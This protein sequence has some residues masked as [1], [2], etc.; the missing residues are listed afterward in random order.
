MHVWGHRRLA[1]AAMAVVMGMVLALALGGI[2]EPA[3]GR[4]GAPRRTDPC[5]GTSVVDHQHSLQ[6]G[7]TPDL[8]ANL[9]PVKG[10]CY[11]DVSKGEAQMTVDALQSVNDEHNEFFFS[12][13]SLHSVRSRIPPDNTARGSTGRELGF[14]KLISFGPEFA[15]LAGEDEQIAEASVGGDMIDRFTVHGTKAFLFVDRSS[16]DSRY[17]FT[18]VRHGVQGDL[19]GATRA[20][21][22]KWVRKYLAATVLVGTESS[23]LVDALVR[24]DGYAY[25]DYP[26]DEITETWVKGPL[27]AVP[28]SQHQVVDDTQSIGG[29][30]LAEVPASMTTDEYVARLGAYGLRGATAEEGVTIA[31]ARVA[32][33][34]IDQ[35][36]VYVW[37][38]GGIAGVGL[39]RYVDRFEPFLQQFL[40]VRH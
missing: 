14:L 36:Q 30:V 34:T 11:V 39:T 23:N 16:R 1:R 21:M 38:R 9:V 3:A 20:P 15:P 7:E 26:D 28:S 29:V 5:P 27:G 17:H 24:I 32:R 8:A 31:D 6:V 19:D 2:G 37:V 35:G 13:V 25:A 10:Y 40:A 22:E 4:G 12:A 18:W 33:F